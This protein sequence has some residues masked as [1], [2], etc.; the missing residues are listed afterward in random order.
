EIAANN[1]LMIQNDELAAVNRGL[2]YNTAFTASGGTGSYAWSLGAGTLPSGLILSSNGTV[3]GVPL[4]AGTYDFVVSV[5]D[6]TL[7]CNRQY[8]LVIN[9]G[10]ARIYVNGAAVGARNGSSWQHAFTS[11]QEALAI[12][13]SGDEIWV[14]KG[15]YSPGQDAASTYNLVSGVKIYGGFAGIESLLSERDLSKLSST[16][17][18]ILDGTNINYHIITGAGT[19]TNATLLDG[20]T[21]TGG[22]S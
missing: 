12:A 18:T 20:F 1:G 11:L 15:T 2:F 7:R 17:E 6:G 13:V 16:N 4:V 8:R 22:K 19:L 3:S 21:I 9:D 10:P 5:T 14:A